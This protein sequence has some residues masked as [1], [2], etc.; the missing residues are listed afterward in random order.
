MSVLA[1]VNDS[2]LRISGRVWAWR[3]PRWLR[4]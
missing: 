4:L 3:P 1:Y 2:D